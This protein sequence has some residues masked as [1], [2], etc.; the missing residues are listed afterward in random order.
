MNSNLGTIVS[1]IASGF[2]SES[3]MVYVLD[4]RASGLDGGTFTSGGFYT[5]VMNTERTNNIE[6]ASMLGNQLTLPAGKY[7]AECV[8]QGFQVGK[9]Q[10]ILINVTDGSTILRGTVA[11]TST[12]SAVQ[13]PSVITGYFTLDG[14]EAIE[15]R[16]R[17]STT[18]SGNGL[19]NACGFGTKEKH[20]QLRVWKV[21]N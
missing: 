2:L 14:E 21:G 17:C 1:P 4:E 16:H 13:V 8:A 6:G 15:V 20:M 11:L 7:Y 10:A 3:N 19:G 12:G 5:R 9:H 18:N